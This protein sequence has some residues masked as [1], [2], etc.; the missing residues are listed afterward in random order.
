MIAHRLSSV[1]GADRILVLDDGPLAESGRHAELLASGGIYARLMAAQAAE[2]D[3]DVLLRAPMLV[4]AGAQPALSLAASGHAHA[5]DHDARRARPR[6]R[7]PPAPTPDPRCPYRRPVATRRRHLGAPARAGP[8]VVGHADVVFLLG[9]AH[10]AAVLGLAVVSSLL[11]RQVAAGRR[12]DALAAGRSALLVPLAALPRPG[13]S[14]GWPTT[15]PTACWPRC[16]SRSTRSSTRW[17]PAY[18]L[19]R[20]SGDLV[21]AVTGDVETVE[22]FFAHTIA[23]AF[24]AVLV[25]GGVLSR[26]R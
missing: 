24:V 16:A 14:P 1:I 8:A 4:E 7:P 18:L 6:Q 17:R 25:P 19:R 9:L 13:P 21:S 10:A 3:S 15:W 11:V 20:R 23:P 12:P 26:W 5:H 2:P 22:Y